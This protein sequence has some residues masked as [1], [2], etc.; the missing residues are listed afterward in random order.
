MVDILS[1]NPMLLFGVAGLLGAGIRGIVVF[2]KRKRNKPKTKFD[3][4]MYI[5]TLVEGISAGIAFSLGL[6]IT[7]IAL[8]V[9]AVAGSGIDT[10]TNQLGIKIMPILKKFAKK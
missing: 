8:V 10:I 2:Y 4:A 5:D 7:W 3:S 6:P 1:L 9:T